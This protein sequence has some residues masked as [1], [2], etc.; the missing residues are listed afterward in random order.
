[1]CEELY[2]WTDSKNNKIPKHEL[3]D[4]YVCNIV[5]KFGKEYLRE[6]GH[7]VIVDR[8]EALNKEH[9]FFKAL[10]KAPEIIGG[11]ENAD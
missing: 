5:M 1:M 6:H 8:F 3:S 7:N 11:E 4:Y 2:Y 9:G 10:R